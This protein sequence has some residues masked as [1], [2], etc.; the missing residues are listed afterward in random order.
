VR[1]RNDDSGYGLITKSL[2][3]LTVAALLAQFVVG[4]LLDDGSGRG[5]GRGRSGESGHGRGRGG[6]DSFEL[7]FGEDG[8]LLF[9]THAT[10]GLTILTLAVVR[11]LWRRLTP[12]PPW[13]PGLSSAE[14][15]AATWTERAL[16]L[17]LFLIPLTGLS[18]LLVSDDLVAAHIATHVLF[19]V[20]LAA[21]LGLVLK[22]Q[23]LDRD[24]LLL[25][26]T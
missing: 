17:C 5:R 20:A 7:G 12:L 14:K 1:L 18:L 22:H 26:M 4:Y 16:Y 9:T 15:V 21:H 6:N 3:W 24:R 19:F 13:A 10:L 2:H 8:D 11:V 25:R 23:L